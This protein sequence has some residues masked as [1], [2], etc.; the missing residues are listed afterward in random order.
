MRKAGV[1]APAFLSSREEPCDMEHTKW[2]PEEFSLHISCPACLGRRLSRMEVGGVMDGHDN[3]SPGVL[4]RCEDCDHRL[5]LYLRW[6][7][8][9]VVLI[10]NTP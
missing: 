9:T 6:A 10:A 3:Q 7:G 2:H 5:W 8:Q 1:S 4:F